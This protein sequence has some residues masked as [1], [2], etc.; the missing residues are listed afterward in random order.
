MQDSQAYD[1]V[2]HQQAAMPEELL[3]PLV[4]GPEHGGQEPEAEPGEAIDLTALR[5]LGESR[6]DV[7]ALDLTAERLC[8]LQDAFAEAAD[9]SCARADR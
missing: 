1:V 7:E 6:T 2:A 5:A 9:D 4:A 8:H 3:G